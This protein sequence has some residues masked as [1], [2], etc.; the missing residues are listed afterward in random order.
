[1]R[2]LG[3]DILRFIAVAL[4]LG[5]HMEP[6]ADPHP[7]I[8]L[9]ITGGWVGVDVFFV[10]SGFLVSGLLFREQL[11]TGKLDIWRFLIRRGLKIYPSFYVMIA[12]S[13]VVM[14]LRGQP[15]LPSALVGELLFV[16]NYIVGIWR[17]T[18]SL[19]VEEHFYLFISLAFAL[20]T[21]RRKGAADVF[22]AVPRL[23]FIMAALCL[24][25]RI[26]N[27]FLWEDYTNRKFLFGTHLRAD[28]LMFGV[29]ISYLWHMR[30]LE[31]KISHVKTSLLVVPGLLCFVPAFIFPLQEHRLI[32]VFGVIPLYLGSGLLLLACMRLKQSENKLLLLLGAFGS[33]SY[34]MYLWHMP[35]EKW[36][37][38]VLTKVFGM[39][40]FTAYFIFYMTTSVI[41]GY[42][43]SKLVEWPVIRFR[44]QFFPSL[45]SKPSPPTP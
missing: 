30:G 44:D 45:S 13:I 18:W 14:L 7:V 22:A 27:L 4:V 12:A 34:S 39:E 35:V 41:V 26:S 33:A 25:C 20:M 31:Q 36:G 6:P 43:M 42:V 23:F 28:S 10:L 17:H 15:I 21:R 24:A 2:N 8:G 19:A 11:A 3:L 32:S 37:W 29:L 40:G 1:M 9:W 38:L 5:R 16:Q